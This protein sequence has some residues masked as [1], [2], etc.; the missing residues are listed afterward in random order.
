MSR[1]RIADWLRALADLIDPDGKPFVRVRRDHSTVGQPLI[2][3][4]IP[5]TPAHG[6]DP[7]LIEKHVRYQ[8]LPVKGL[9]W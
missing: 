8:R 2:E 9:G 6:T 7:A 1:A 5:F 3:S 4:N